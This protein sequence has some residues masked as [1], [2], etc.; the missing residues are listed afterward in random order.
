MGKHSKTRRSYVKLAAL[1]VALAGILPHTPVADA[2]P[3]VMAAPGTTR[4]APAPLIQAAPAVNAAVQP[5]TQYA[6]QAAPATIVV[7]NRPI[8]VENKIVQETSPGLLVLDPAAAAKLDPATIVRV[9]GDNIKESDIPVLAEAAAKSAAAGIALGLP[10]AGL[11]TVGGAVVG[12]ATGAAAGTAAGA[13]TG[14][15]LG[16][17]GG[18]IA[19]GIAGGAAGGTI[20]GIAGTVVATPV[21]AVAVP[22]L[23]VIP[24]VAAGTVA[25]GIGVLGG[26]VLG[27]VAGGALGAPI[28]AASGGVIG[29]GVGGTTGALAG[30][31]VGAGVGGTGAAALG[32][33]VGVATTPAAQDAGKRILGDVVWD[34]ENN[35]RIRNGYDGLVG[36]KPGGNVGG[37]TL[38]EVIGGA[39]GNPAAQVNQAIEQGRNQVDQA[40]SNLDASTPGVHIPS[41]GELGI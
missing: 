20:L 28:G 4:P 35:T 19:G 34:L 8:V 33:A 6:P 25:A 23:P 24:G 18:A 1:P 12:G 39:P 13:A 37:R 29:A 17:A 15:A 2:A 16:T 30:G 40:L 14:A 27:A 10:V 11:T 22:A 41:L 3:Q 7:D 21:G 9:F 38:N 32:T 5:L 36:E 26:G 31:A